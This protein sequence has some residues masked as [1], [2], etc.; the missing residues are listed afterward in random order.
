LNRF[1][2]GSGGCAAA[3]RLLFVGPMRSLVVLLVLV[4]TA[5]ADP[6]GMTA[7]VASPVEPGD[8]DS[9]RL[10][11]AMSDAAALA[12]FVIAAKSE[13]GDAAADLGFAMYVAGGPIV[14]LIHHHNG[15]AVASLALRVALPVV[16]GAVGAALTSGNCSN[17]D[18]C[19]FAALGGA[20][21]GAVV[22]AGAASAIDIGY[23]SRGDDAPATRPAPI[24]PPAPLGP[25]E[26]HQVRVGVTFAF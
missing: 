20:L 1:D 4:A 11:T 24:L 16:A 13:D 7:P 21:I 25:A 18:D 15:R 23:L 10:Q 2:V 12:M 14:H 3:Q 26:P 8:I 19:G 22:G 17:D 6:P 5:H 9:Y